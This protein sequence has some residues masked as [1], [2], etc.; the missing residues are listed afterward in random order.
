MFRRDYRH[1]IM[2]RDPWGD[3]DFLFGA[4]QL[5]LVIRELPV[6]YRER[7]AGVS[8]MRAFRHMMNLLRMLGH[9]FLQVQVMRPIARTRHDAL[10]E[11]PS[12]VSVGDKRSP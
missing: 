7:V 6:H 5:R 12:R 2:G 4:A 3:Y 1:M 9:G 11:M 10:G 8:K